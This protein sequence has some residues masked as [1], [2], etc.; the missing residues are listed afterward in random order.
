MKGSGLV[1]V[2]PEPK[3]LRNIFAAHVAFLDGNKEVGL[4]GSPLP[5]CAPG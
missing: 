5:P 4:W 3:H 2:V 1:A